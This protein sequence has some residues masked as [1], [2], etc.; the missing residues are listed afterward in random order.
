MNNPRFKVRIPELKDNLKPAWGLPFI[1]NFEYQ[2]NIFPVAKRVR[3]D[4]KH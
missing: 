4:S 2:T 3:K 1:L